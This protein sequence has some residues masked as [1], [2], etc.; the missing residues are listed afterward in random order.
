MTKL[1]IALLLLSSPQSQEGSAKMI[2]ITIK[3]VDINRGGNLIVFIFQ[4]NG[5]PTKHDKALASKTL[6][7]TEAVHT[8][9]FTLPN[10]PEDL[11][12]KVLHDEDMDGKTSKNWTGIYPSEGLGFS[13]DQKIGTFGPPSYKKSKLQKSQYLKGVTLTLTYP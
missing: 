4:D 5:F 7:A 1:F 13:Q 6:P 3:N 11:A 10:Y 9:Q 2:N 8:L 12:F